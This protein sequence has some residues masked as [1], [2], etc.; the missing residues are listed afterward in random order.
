MKV[1]CAIAA[2]VA[3]LCF[4]LPT[5]YSAAAEGGSYTYTRAEVTDAYICSEA[6]LTAALFAIPYTY[7][8]RVISEEGIWYYV[9]YAEDS[10]VYRAVYGYVLKSRLTLLDTAPETVWLYYTLTVTYSQ[11]S[12]GYLPT[13]SDITA[14]AAFYGNY[15]SGASGYSYVLCQGS[16]GYIAGSTEN[17]DLVQTESGGEEEQQGGSTSSANGKVIAGVV[18]GVSAAAALVLVFL[19]GRKNKYRGQ[20]G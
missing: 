12:Q 10:G 20:D 5:A 4:S 7:S 18:L 19:S 1:L 9:Q 15:Y 8:V 11:S 2:A 6:D 16:F 3:A 17:Y 13:L 14:Q